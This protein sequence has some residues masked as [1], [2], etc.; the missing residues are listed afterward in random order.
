M[1][2]MSGVTVVESQKQC[3]WHD[4]QD[5]QACQGRLL[6]YSHLGQAELPKLEPRSAHAYMLESRLWSMWTWMSRIGGQPWQ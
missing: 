4:V 1:A 2:R 5:R 6:S 3:V